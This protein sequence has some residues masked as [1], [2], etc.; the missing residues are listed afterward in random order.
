MSYPLGMPS[1]MIVGT[2]VTT[3]DR[4]DQRQH[5]ITLGALVTIFGI[6]AAAIE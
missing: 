3:V 1:G 4:V 6:A 5:R 2:P